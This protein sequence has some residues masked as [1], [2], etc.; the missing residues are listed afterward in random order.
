MIE[1]LVDLPAHLR[2][3]LASALESGLLTAPYSTTSLRSVLG[4]RAGDEDLLGALDVGRLANFV[5]LTKNPLDNIS[6]VRL[7]RYVIHDGRL[8]EPGLSIVE[9]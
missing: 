8:Y 1:A 6:N 4:V 5:V 9:P 7:I 3:R 2:K